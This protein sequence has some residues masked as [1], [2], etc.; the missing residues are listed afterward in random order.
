MIHRAKKVTIQWI[1]AHCDIRW[2]DNADEL[3]K[4][5]SHMPQENV[6]TTYE[7]AKQI[8]KQNTKE[9]QGLAA[10]PWEGVKL[11]HMLAFFLSQCQRKAQR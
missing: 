2:N 4:M 11:S 8:A 7:T 5:G 3:A 10:V 6:N 9:V 1:P